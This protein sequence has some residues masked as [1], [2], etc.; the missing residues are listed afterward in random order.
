MQVTWDT[1]QQLYTFKIKRG[2][3]KWHL[4]VNETHKNP[5]DPELQSNFT[6]RLSEADKKKKKKKKMSGQ[7]VSW[8]TWR[9]ESCA[10]QGTTEEKLK[11]N[12]PMTLWKEKK[13]KNLNNLCV[14]LG[15]G[16]LEAS[17]SKWQQCS[18]W[19]CTHEFCYAW[20]FQTIEK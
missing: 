10:S 14:I 3:H 1:R 8:K 19:F 11:R 13:K 6:C 4:N 16:G 5:Q 15:R 17:P 7:L 20:V 18:V 9:V 12:L 2:K